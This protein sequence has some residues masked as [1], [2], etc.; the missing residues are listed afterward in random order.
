[1]ITVFVQLQ[2]RWDAQTVQ[3]LGVILAM[4]LQRISATDNNGCGSHLFK[5]SSWAAIGDTTS[6]SRG[7]CLRIS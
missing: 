5:I 6:C 3:S 2:C 4:G 7:A 1:M